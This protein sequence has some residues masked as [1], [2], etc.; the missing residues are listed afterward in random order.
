MLVPSKACGVDDGADV[1]L[2]LGGPHRAVA[3]GHLP[4]HD[5]RTQSALTAIVRR[6]DPAGIGQED[7]ELI[8]G[9]ADLSLQPGQVTAARGGQDGA[10]LSIK[11]RRLAAS[12][13]AARSVTRSASAN[14][15]PARAAGERARD[16][17][18][19]RRRRRRRGPDARGRSDA[20]PRVPAGPCSGL[21]STP[22]AGVR[23]SSPAPRRRPRVGE[24]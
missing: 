4:L 13:E 14:T 8:A 19:P 10:E 21:R 6:L 22:R 18:W 12:V 5:G 17:R 3:V 16:R 9:A 1:G 23:P 15:D 2:A 7:Q 20:R 11:L 24:A